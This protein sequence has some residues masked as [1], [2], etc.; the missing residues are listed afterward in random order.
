MKIEFIFRTHIIRQC[1]NNLRKT[2][3]ELESRKLQLSF[4]RSKGEFADSII[5]YSN[6]VN[7]VTTEMTSLLGRIIE[8]TEN[9]ARA[10]EE[11]DNT[12]AKQFSGK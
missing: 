11:T 4:A 1:V 5:E 3:S 2:R 12:L 9:A 7:E 6:A 8:K 10:I